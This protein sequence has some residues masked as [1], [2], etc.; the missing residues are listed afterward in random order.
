MAVVTEEDAWPWPS[1]Q[2]L[3]CGAPGLRQRLIEEDG[4]D[5][6][7]L[8]DTDADN[9]SSPLVVV[10]LGELEFAPPSFKGLD[11]LPLGRARVIRLRRSEIDAALT[12]WTPDA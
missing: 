4:A 9:G 2:H 10:E 3:G 7:Q 6:P 11:D 1:L 8:I 12:N 5:W